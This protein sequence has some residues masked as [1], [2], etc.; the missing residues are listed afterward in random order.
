MKKMNIDAMSFQGKEDVLTRISFMKGKSKF[1]QLISL[2]NYEIEIPLTGVAVMLACCFLVMNFQ[3][4]RSPKNY[5]YPI[6]VIEAGG[7]YEIY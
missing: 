4:H 3:I 7:Q 2:L 5:D 6:M 1:K